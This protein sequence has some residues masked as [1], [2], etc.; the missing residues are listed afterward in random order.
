MK[1]KDNLERD[2]EIAKSVEEMK[3]NLTKVKKSVDRVGRIKISI[4]SIVIVLVC[5]VIIISFFS[6]GKKE[7]VQVVTNESVLKEAIKLSKLNTYETFYEGIAVKHEK[8]DISRKA[9]YYVSYKASVKYSINLDEIDVSRDDV[10]KNYVITL[11]ELTLN[12]PNVFTDSLDYI[13]INNSYTKES[14]YSEALAMAEQDVY[15]ESLLNI[16]MREA[17]LYNTKKVIT[18][19]LTPFISDNTEKY[20]IVFV[21]GDN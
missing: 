2:D 20:G 9:V 6:G 21:G 12:K 11:P 16:N 13:F 3:D 18:A 19:L 7:T 15:E 1:D 4:Y 14:V 5:I 8:D 17:A 10:N